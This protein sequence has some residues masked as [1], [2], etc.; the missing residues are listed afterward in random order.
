VTYFVVALLLDF[1]SAPLA[2]SFVAVLA[3]LLIVWKLLPAG[4][5]G[6]VSRE[7][8]DWEIPARVVVATVVVLLITEGATIL[9]PHL[10]GLL[11]TFPAYATILA[12]FIHRFEGADACAQFLRGVVTGSLT[13]AVF[14]LI[15]SLIIRSGLLIAMGLAS[16]VAMIMHYFLFYTLRKAKQ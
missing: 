4:A 3:F 14:F 8:S 12:V 10:S 7:T 2:L 6:N 11:T 13:T 1:V 16:F 9:G 15:A 5:V